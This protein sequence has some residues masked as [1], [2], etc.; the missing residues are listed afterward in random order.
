MKRT[1]SII[2]SVLVGLVSLNIAISQTQRTD[3]NTRLGA[4]I[5]QNGVA[6]VEVVLS[7]LIEEKAILEKLLKLWG[8]EQSQQKKNE[9][10]STILIQLKGT[11]IS[12]LKK[13]GIKFKILRNGIKIEKEKGKSFIEAQG[14]S[15]K[16]TGRD[17]LFFYYCYLPIEAIEQVAELESVA[18]ID[19]VYKSSN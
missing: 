9:L 10:T 13:N 14:G 7:D 1:L 5:I 3:N 18:G 6:E 15:I 12:E 8:I 19:K 17:V 2:A 4:R 11:Q 16:W